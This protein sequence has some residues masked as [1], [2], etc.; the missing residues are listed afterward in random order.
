MKGTVDSLI[1]KINN[2]TLDPTKIP[3]ARSDYDTFLPALGSNSAGPG[4]V[5]FNSGYSSLSS[6]FNSYNAGDID[7]AA[8]AETLFNTYGDTLVNGMSYSMNLSY[9]SPNETNF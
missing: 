1:A 6:L 3:I 4:G 7:G 2:K 8:L 5:L 9:T